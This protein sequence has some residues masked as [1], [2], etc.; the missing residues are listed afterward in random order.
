MKRFRL[1]IL[2]AVAVLVSAPVVQAEILA[3]LNYE[4]KP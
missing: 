3:M 2:I 1:P 4:T